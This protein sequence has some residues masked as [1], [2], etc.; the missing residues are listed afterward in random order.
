ME[1]AEVNANRSTR[2]PVDECR[3]PHLNDRALARLSEL[4]DGEHDKSE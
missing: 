1:L 3:L 4:D 2:L